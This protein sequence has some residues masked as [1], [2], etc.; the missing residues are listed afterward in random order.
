MRF[1]VASGLANQEAVRGLIA[2]LEKL[3]HSVTYDWTRHGSMQAEPHE[4][5]RV[6]NAEMKGVVCAAFVVV[7]TPGGFGTHVELGAALACGIPVILVGT[8]EDRRAGRDYD[9]VFHFHPFVKR[10]ETV[11]EVPAAIEKW[12]R[13]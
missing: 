5:G 12:V 4:W 6:A 10:V 8:R 1:Y 13:L 9:C 2:T 7:L 3:G 11:A